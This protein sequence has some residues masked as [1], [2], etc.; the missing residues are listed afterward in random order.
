MVG[1][2]DI[3]R[4]A[5]LPVLATRADLRLHLVSRNAAVRE[6]LGR[7]WRIADGHADISAALRTATF[8]AAFV[9]AA[10]EAHPALVKE[11]LAARVPVFVD[12]PLADNYARAERLAEL[13][14][15][16]GV[17]LFVGFNRRYAPV[18][19]ELRGRSASLVRMEKHRRGPLHAAR[20]TVFDDFIHVVDT[21]RMLAPATAEVAD[22]Q[23]VMRG[24]ALEAVTLTLAAPGF[25]ATGAMH[26]AS[27]L[28]EERLELIG[29]DG[30]LTIDN[31]ADTIEIRGDEQRRSRRGDWTSVAHQRG[32]AAMCDS[33]LKIVESGRPCPTHDL[34]WTHRVCEMILERIASG[35][36]LA[37]GS[38]A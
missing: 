32:F 8:D 7:A 16:S 3:A 21:L 2:G 11:L 38:G 31:M 15:R 30:R 13:A 18:Y 12:K 17:P 9:H 35:T 14:E 25:I 6:E 37:P 20:Q 34:L 1:L 23:T 4:K 24:E 33:F 19:A 36:G 5:Y 22:M 26:R 28:D 29:A 10:T 27:G